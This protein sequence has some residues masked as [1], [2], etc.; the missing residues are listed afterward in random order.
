M[1]TPHECRNMQDI[2]TEIDRIDQEVINLLG[3][4][5][6]YVQKAAQFKTNETAVRA[7]E[8]FHSML[9]QRRVWAAQAGLD[10]DTIA[11]LYRDLVHYFID[12]EIATWKAETEG[13]HA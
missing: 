1:K 12:E 3:Q 2:H 9:D 10:P 11:N 8:R 7:P 5:F 6:G 13:K 4:R